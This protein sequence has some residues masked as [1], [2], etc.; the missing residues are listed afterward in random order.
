[1]N[2]Q[3]TWIPLPQATTFV[4]VSVLE[5]IQVDLASAELGRV[6]VAK[7]DEKYAAG[8]LLC[9]HYGIPVENAANCVVVTATRGDQTE[10]AACLMR[11][12]SRSDLNG[13]VR[14]HLGARKVFLT[15][16]DEVLQLT[17]MEYGSIT[18]VGLPRDW[19]V[20]IDATLGLSPYLVMGSGLLRTKIRIPTDLFLKTTKAHA[21]SGLTKDG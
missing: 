15:D 3:L 5:R 21:I 10:R 12:G 2:E 9:A 6:M 20:L 14:R 1:L 17:N 8:D 16:R 11:P 7:I 18:A 19:S 13:V 4:A